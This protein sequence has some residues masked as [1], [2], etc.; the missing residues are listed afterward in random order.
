MKRIKLR[1]TCSIQGPRLYSMWDQDRLITTCVSGKWRDAAA[2]LPE[3]TRALNLALTLRC[4]L[5]ARA[6]SPHLAARKV[7]LVLSLQEQ[8]KKLSSPSSTT[9]RVS[10]YQST[11]LSSSGSTA[12]LK[13]L[14]ERKV[15][16][17]S[18]AL[19]TLLTQMTLWMILPTSE[20]IWSPK[21]WT[22]W[23]QKIA[24]ALPQNWTV[25]RL[26]LIPLPCKLSYK[27]QDGMPLRTITSQWE[28]DLW[29]FSSELETRSSVG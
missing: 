18:S 19:V 7:W 6:S 10:N 15:S 17:S 9:W 24:L 27:S 14:K 8:A 5:N 20:L 2:L 1:T 11:K 25:I 22:T 23:G 4:L 29:A 3:V 12:S 26:L 16:S 21:R 13:N 28:E